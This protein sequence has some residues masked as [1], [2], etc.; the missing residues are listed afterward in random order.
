MA[1]LEAPDGSVIAMPQEQ[2]SATESGA[3][4]F[5]LTVDGQ[6]IWKDGFDGPYK[7]KDVAV[8]LGTSPALDATADAISTPAYP[9]LKFAPPPTSYAFDNE[10]EGSELLQ[11]R[12]ASKIIDVP[13]GASYP[14]GSGGSVDLYERFLAGGQ[15]WTDWTKVSTATA[16]PFRG[17]VLRLGDGTYQFYTRA[18]DAGTGDTEADKPLGESQTA[19]TVLTASPYALFDNTALTSELGTDWLTTSHTT[20]SLPVRATYP[21]DSGHYELY[22]QYL[23]SIPY[24]GSDFANATLIGTYSSPSVTVNLDGA[25]GYYCFYAVAVDANGQRQTYAYPTKSEADIDLDR[26][27]PASHVDPIP[28]TASVGPIDVV[29]TGGDSTVLYSRYRPT[30]GDPWG[31]WLPLASEGQYGWDVDRQTGF[32]SYKYPFALGGGFYEF[33]SILHGLRGQ[34]RSATGSCRHGNPIHTAA[35]LDPELACVS[36]KQSCPDDAI[37]GGVPIRLRQCRT[38]AAHGPEWPA[39]RE[40]DRSPRNVGL[41]HLL[42]AR[43]WGRDI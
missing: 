18:I 29:A 8:M 1:T 36:G 26:T 28:A 9:I 34:R 13:Y 24:G 6:T 35:H 43:Q 15:N 33:Y 32:Y 40:M 7:V 25:D 11:W 2:V 17:I 4:S 30:T 19:Q 20:I 23:A 5:S 37:H 14:G 41:A 42:L 3:Y 22:E 21:S 31:Q 16:S 10:G 38:L 12:T 39:A 27:P